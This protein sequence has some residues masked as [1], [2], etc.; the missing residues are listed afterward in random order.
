MQPMPERT[1]LALDEYVKYGEC[2]DFI[3]AVLRND[4]TWAVFNAD[5]ENLAAL[6]AIVR[7]VYNHI[8]SAAWGSQKAVDEWRAARRAERVEPQRSEL[9]QRLWDLGDTMIRAQAEGLR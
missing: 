6:E 4:L 3:E 1:K 9:G 5:A 8:P 2:G 7:Y